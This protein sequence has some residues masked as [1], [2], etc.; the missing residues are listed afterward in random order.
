[1]SLFP[2]IPGFL[3]DREIQNIIL[4]AEE[5]GMFSSKAKG[6]LTPQDY[7]TPS[8]GKRTQSISDEDLFVFSMLIPVLETNHHLNDLSICMFQSPARVNEVTVGLASSVPR[9]CAKATRTW[10]LIEPTEPPSRSA[11]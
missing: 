4:Q 5:S 6:G 10:E 8:N 11:Q 1:M 2:E 3:D 9:S 7:F